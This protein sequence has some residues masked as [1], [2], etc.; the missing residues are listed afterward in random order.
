MAP[1]RRGSVRQRG[2]RWQARLQLPDGREVSATL[3]TKR[4]AERWLRDQFAAR[5]RASQGATSREAAGTP[6]LAEWSQTWLADLTHLRPSS[7]ARAVS[8]VRR[9]ILPNFAGMRLN[10]ISAADVRRWQAMLVS[11]GT[12]PSTATRTLRVLGACLQ[13]AADDG[14][15]PSNPARGI[16]PPKVERHEQRYLSPEEVARLADAID[17]RY[18]G[19]IYLLAYGGLRIGEASGLRVRSVNPLRSTVTITEQ[20]VEVAGRLHVGPPKTSA[21]RRTVPL[22]RFVMDELRPYLEGKSPDDLVF[23]SPDGGTLRRTLWAARFYRPAVQEAGLAPLRVHDLRHTAVAM[24]ITAGANALEITRRAG[25]TSSAFVLDRYG[26]L[27]DMCSNETTDRL[28][29]MARKAIA[30]T[31]T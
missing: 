26:H 8:A 21:G 7:Y 15:I 13:V 24:W 6:T 9:Q 16:R 5:E 10:E 18:R 29:Q 3:P 25:H 19:L 12:A 31:R 1:N 30:A 14:L 20:V 11:N 22:P 27:L 28:D 2:T 23:T 4:E 17:T